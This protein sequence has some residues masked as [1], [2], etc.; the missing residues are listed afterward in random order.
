[1]KNLFTF[2]IK[3]DPLFLNSSFLT[4]FLSLN[5][6]NYLFKMNHFHTPTYLTL[7]FLGLITGRTITWETSFPYVI[8]ISQTFSYNVR[9][10]QVTGEEIKWPPSKFL[11]TASMTVDKITMLSRKLE[12]S[13]IYFHLQTVL[14]F[15]F[16]GLSYTQSIT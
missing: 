4:L 8:V 5:F 16:I 10:F 1:M 14:N 15:F 12:K 6:W 13:H 2:F 11:P 7:V 9:E 3:Y